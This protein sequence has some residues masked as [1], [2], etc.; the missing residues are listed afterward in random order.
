[1]DFSVNSSLPSVAF[2]FA[3]LKRKTHFG[4]HVGHRIR[5]AH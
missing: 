2:V 3:V 5:A 4:I 1:M